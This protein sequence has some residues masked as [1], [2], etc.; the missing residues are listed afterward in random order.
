MVER[1]SDGV[2]RAQA[3]RSTVFTVVVGP[4]E[5]GVDPLQEATAKGRTSTAMSTPKRATVR[6]AMDTG[7]RYTSGRA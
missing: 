1:T 2:M 7:A 4:V 5:A 6:G 3:V